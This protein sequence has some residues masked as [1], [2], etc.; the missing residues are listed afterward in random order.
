MLTHLHG[1][2]WQ[3]WPPRSVWFQGQ[4]GHQIADPDFLHERGLDINTDP[5]FGRTTDLVMA[6]GSRPGQ[7]AI[8]VPGGSEGQLDQHRSQHSIALR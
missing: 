2:M 7:E 3:H 4:H 8:M 6:L 1:S 5:D